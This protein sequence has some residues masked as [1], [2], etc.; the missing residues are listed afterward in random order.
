MIQSLRDQFCVKDGE[1]THSLILNSKDERVA[2]V[3]SIV[4]RIK[5]ACVYFSPECEYYMSK[6]EILVVDD[7]E[8]NAYTTMG[9]IIVVYT[10]LLNY[11]KDLE[12]KGK[13]T[14]YKEVSF[15]IRPHA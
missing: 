5:E 11:F 14:N 6:M 13:I 4:N 15:S 12:K 9:S 2:L 1:S 3:T 7:D 10:G 8:V